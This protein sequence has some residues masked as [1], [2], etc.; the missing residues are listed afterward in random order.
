MLKVTR[1]RP[2]NG[3]ISRFLMPVWRNH[4]S[5]SNTVISESFNL[6]EQKSLVNG[7]EAAI[8]TS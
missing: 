7:K 3:F 6:N 4:V 8:L 1:K 5:R 2:Q